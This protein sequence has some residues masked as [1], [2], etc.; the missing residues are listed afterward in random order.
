MNDSRKLS[1]SR[2]ARQRTTRLLHAGRGFDPARAE[3][4][5]VN[6]P[7]VRASTILTR[8]VETLETKAPYGTKGTDTTRALC[9]ALLEIEPA[10]ECLLYPSGL[11][12]IAGVVLGL[13]STGDH[14]LLSD[15]LYY[16]TRR[17]MNTLMARFGVS[18]SYFSPRAGVDE[19]IGMMEG[20][21]SL[22]FLESPASDSLEV[23]D[24]PALAQAARERG[25]TPVIDNT[26]SA[27]WLFDAI[28]A[29][30]S[31]SIQALT[32]YQSGHADVLMG[33]ALC[34]AEVAERVRTAALTM[35][36]CVGAD[37]AWLVLR[38]LRSMDVRMRQ[39]EK[40]ALKVAEWL[41]TR[42]EVEVVLHPA[43]PHCHGHE[44]F[45]R[46]F[47]GAAALFSFVLKPDYGEAEGRR[48]V[49][50]LQLFGIGA[51]W[52]GY[53]SLVMLKDMR[54]LRST[55]WPHAPWLVRLS[56]GLEDADDL[57]ADLESAFAQMHAA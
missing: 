31:V 22:L 52:G 49:D 44:I 26:W 15:G 7:V 36:Q 1:D 6:P 42:D 43:L 23:L 46:D 25:I 45:R 41:M 47:S 37:D 57:I 18:A 55:E 17:L 30:C 9:E 19:I 32:K 24:V 34:S 38:G 11:A 8:D 40:N 51:S 12:A 28:S 33:A 3:T 35:G 53:E 10:A 56:V 21:T 5:P 50:S 29:G 39:A 14:V 16:P 54:R 20:N 4:G 2:P 27:G 48:F 13:T